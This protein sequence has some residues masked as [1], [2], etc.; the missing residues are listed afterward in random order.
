MRSRLLLSVVTL[1]LLA[2]PACGGGD[3]PAAEDATE[4]AATESTPAAAAS[5]AEGEAASDDVCADIADRTI[6]RLQA[7]VA[8][9]EDLTAEDLQERNAEV[10]QRFQEEIQGLQAEADEAGCSEQMAALLQERADQITG[11]GFFAQLIRS[12]LLGSPP[13]GSSEAPPTESAS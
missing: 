3:E 1:L 7:L 2:L 13:P 10:T 8:E 9:F 12:G 11:D 4:A 5:E 6:E